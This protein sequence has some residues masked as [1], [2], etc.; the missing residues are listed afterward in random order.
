MM[1]CPKGCMPKPK[2]L[3]T[4]EARRRY[5]CTLCGLRYTTAEQIV[6]D[7]TYVNGPPPS[8]RE[9][10]HQSQVKKPATSRPRTA[11]KTSRPK[12]S[13]PLPKTAAD[14]PKGPRPSTVARHRMEDL[15]MSRVDDLGY[16]I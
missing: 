9:Y 3:E 7:G 1:K 6:P 14:L 13:L 2:V 12:T 11:A 8:Q 16:P 5:E 15:A 4:R 10:T